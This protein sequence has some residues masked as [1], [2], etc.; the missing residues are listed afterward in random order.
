MVFIIEYRL[1]CNKTALLSAV[2]L[3]ALWLGVQYGRLFLPGCG[4]AVSVLENGTSHDAIQM[5]SIVFDNKVE[6]CIINVVVVYLANTVC[7]SGT[8]LKINYSVIQGYQ[9]KLVNCL[10]LRENVNVLN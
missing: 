7:F 2:D 6:P 3:M 1:T 10:R 4:S 9:F 8:E 5:S